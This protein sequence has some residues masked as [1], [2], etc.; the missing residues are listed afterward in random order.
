L[1]KDDRKPG[2]PGRSACAFWIPLPQ[3]T[4]REP[5]ATRPASG[6]QLS[7]ARV[8]SLVVAQHLAIGTADVIPGGSRTLWRRWVVIVDGSRCR[9][10]S[11][12]E[13]IT[14]IRLP[15]VH[16]DRRI[17]ARIRRRGSRR[18]RIGRCGRRGACGRGSAA[19]RRR[20]DRA[21]RSGRAAFVLTTTSS[22][23]RFRAENETNRT[24]NRNQGV[25][26]HGHAPRRILRPVMEPGTWLRRRPK[27]IDVRNAA[28][29]LGPH[30]LYAR[31][32]WRN[33]HFKASRMDF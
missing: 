12:I 29:C 13:R 9:G 10:R 8:N 3:T 21:R 19:A 5:G 16:C 11:R 28:N 17:A 18:C 15:S 24:R 33:K 25:L 2:R 30:S 23:G 6:G 31:R 27:K 22:L 32:F 7:C 1:T 4:W 26:Q 14:P 20:R